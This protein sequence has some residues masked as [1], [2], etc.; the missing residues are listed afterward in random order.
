MF[1]IAK[2]TNKTSTVEDMLKT[3]FGDVDGTSITT[4]FDNCMKEGKTGIELQ[5]CVFKELAE[6]SDDEKLDIW[7]FLY[8]FVIVG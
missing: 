2:K 7:D 6:K 8:H 5:N 3:K 1:K 4:I